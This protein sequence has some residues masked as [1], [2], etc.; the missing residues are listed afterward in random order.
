MSKDFIWF[1]DEDLF[2]GSERWCRAKHENEALL[3]RVRD[4][5]YRGLSADDR[6]AVRKLAFSMLSDATREDWVKVQEAEREFRIESKFDDPDVQF[7]ESK[8]RQIIIAAVVMIAGDLSEKLVNEVISDTAQAHYRKRKS[9]FRSTL[10][11]NKGGRPSP[12]WTAKRKVFLLECYDE[13]VS[14]GG[15]RP[16]IN[17]YDTW[18][19]RMVSDGVLIIEGSRFKDPVSG[20]KFDGEKIRQ[21]ILDL[22]EE[23]ERHLQWISNDPW[24]DDLISGGLAQ[25]ASG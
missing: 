2:G 4:G 22:K 17:A 25:K 12:W 5:T 24:I 7:R 14:K 23:R 13:A 1:N 6:T 11:K 10:P 18:T 19:K 15:P 9:V 16:Y 3:N 21:K 20:K 8:C